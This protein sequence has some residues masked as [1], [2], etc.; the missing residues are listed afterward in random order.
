VDYFLRR[1]TAY[2]DAGR[3]D[4]RMGIAARDPT[5]E[6]IR[7]LAASHSAIALEAVRIPGHH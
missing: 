2:P 5:D 1:L 4:E 6:Q 3:H 7:A